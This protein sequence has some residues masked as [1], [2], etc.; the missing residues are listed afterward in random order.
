MLEAL[1]LEAA[2]LPPFGAGADA[3]VSAEE[4]P[5]AVCAYAVTPAVASRITN[6]AASAQDSRMEEF[7]APTLESA[8]TIITR[9]ARLN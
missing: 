5:G 9:T 3:D 4:G 6:G 8:Q 1:S 2:E 7:F